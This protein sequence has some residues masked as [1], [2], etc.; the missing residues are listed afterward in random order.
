MDKINY[1]E[2]KL[3]EN[4]MNIRMNNWLH[5]LI[6]QQE[7]LLMFNQKY[8]GRLA[9]KEWLIKGDRNSSFFERSATSVE[10]NRKLRR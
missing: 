8:W 7:K 9:R 2:E 1:V 10:K 3:L 6:K 5:R 4:P